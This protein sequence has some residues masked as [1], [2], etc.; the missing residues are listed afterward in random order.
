MGIDYWKRTTWLKLRTGCPGDLWNLWRSLK[1]K[2]IKYESNCYI[3]VKRTGVL[4]AK[5][6]CG[7]DFQEAGQCNLIVRSRTGTK[8]YEGW[9]HW[10]EKKCN[11]D[12]GRCPHPPTRVPPQDPAGAPRTTC[13]WQLLG[14]STETKN[15]LGGV[16]PLGGE[17]MLVKMSPD[18]RGG[19]SDTC[20]WDGVRCW[21]Q[22]ANFSIC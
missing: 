2:S 17:E 10:A 12:Q 11:C 6:R 15:S 4:K 16:V 20:G 13:T 1:N 22:R 8:N 9:Y 19:V 3:S 18:C 5:M 7:Q 21:L 14:S